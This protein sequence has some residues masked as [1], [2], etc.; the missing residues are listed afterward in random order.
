MN[1]F[2]SE[3]KLINK[4]LK[5]VPSA[6]KAFYDMFA[7]KMYGI[8]LRFA[9]VEGEADDIMQEGFVKV[10]TKLDTFRH[11]G[12]LEGW[13]RR[14]IVNTAISYIKKNSD[15][16]VE[17]DLNN[18]GET[19]IVEDE[20]I[21]NLS[22]EELIKM[23]QLLPER[24]RMVFNLYVYEGYCHKE[25]AEMLDITESTSKAQLSKAKQILKEKLE[26]IRVKSYETVYE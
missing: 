12:S 14:I 5:G 18:I 10:F 3:K 15:Y 16:K 11:E 24:K 4:C 20:A 23:I 6:Q 8:C 22:K 13:V 9:R 1:I 19:E 17:V 7:R 2:A 25:I 21:S 26:K